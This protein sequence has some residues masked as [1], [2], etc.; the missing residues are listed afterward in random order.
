MLAAVAFSVMR[1]G[2]TAGDRHDAGVLTQQPGQ[3]QL[4]R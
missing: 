4:V 2:A 1:G 3:R